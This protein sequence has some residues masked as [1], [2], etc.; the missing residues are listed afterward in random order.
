MGAE[1]LL[2]KL[3]ASG[4]TALPNADFLKN[5]CEGVVQATT[6]KNDDGHAP[7]ENSVCQQLIEAINPEAQANITYEQA[8]E[9]VA[10]TS[11][12]DFTFNNSGPSNG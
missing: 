6:I 8:P 3:E 7:T 10:Q 4:T 1:T 2:E 12:F 5:M 9:Q 11:D